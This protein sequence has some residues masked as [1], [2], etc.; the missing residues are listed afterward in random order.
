MTLKG[1]S[2]LSDVFN[3][4]LGTREE[5]RNYMVDYRMDTI[6][7]MAQHPRSARLEWY[8]NVYKENG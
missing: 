2:G 3:L 4:L 1:R 6:K 7:T 5:N 8:E